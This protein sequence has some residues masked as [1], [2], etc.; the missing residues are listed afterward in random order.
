MSAC[1]PETIGKQG[2]V[3]VGQYFRFD[4]E[5]FLV[6]RNL[7]EILLHVCAACQYPPAEKECAKKDGRPNGIA[8]IRKMRGKPKRDGIKIRV[9]RKTAKSQLE[10]NAFGDEI[11]CP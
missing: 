5:E 7:K 9:K 3:A 8:G 10:P 2:S 1:A 4:P 6:W 11:I